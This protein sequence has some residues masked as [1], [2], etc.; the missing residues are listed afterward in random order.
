[1]QEYVVSQPQ[2]QLA[3]LVVLV[4]RVVF[5]GLEEV[6]DFGP[7]EVM[8]LVELDGHLDEL[9]VAH[10]HDAVADQQALEVQPAALDYAVLVF[11]YLV[12]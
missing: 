8:R 7:E 3:E 2:S 6:E 9:V 1:M 4:F 5:A 10:V 12:G 11:E